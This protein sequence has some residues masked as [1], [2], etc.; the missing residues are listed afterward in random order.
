MTPTIEEL[1]PDFNEDELREAEAS[2]TG[3]AKLLLEM[4]ERMS[5]DGTLK[6]LLEKDY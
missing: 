4:Y 5:A 2:L 3:Y 6:K 1:Y